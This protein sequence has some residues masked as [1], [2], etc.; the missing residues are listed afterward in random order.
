MSR[1]RRMIEVTSYWV[2]TAFERQLRALGF[3]LN[4][5]V[6]CSFQNLKKGVASFAHSRN[7][8]LKHIAAEPCVT[9]VCDILLYCGGLDR[10]VSRMTTLVALSFCFVSSETKRYCFQ[11]RGELFTQ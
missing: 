3:L 7:L 2:P 9:F 1:N 5:R 11:F 6:P 4:V 10:T 8:S